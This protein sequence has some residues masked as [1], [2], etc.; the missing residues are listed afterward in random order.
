MSRVVVEEEFD[1]RGVLERLG[2]G[3]E[4]VRIRI[5]S[6]RIGLGEGIFNSIRT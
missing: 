5:H 1:F 6:L 4:Q 2:G 3:L